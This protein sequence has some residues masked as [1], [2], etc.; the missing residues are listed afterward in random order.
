MNKLNFISIIVL[1][2]TFALLLLIDIALAV[3]ADL[4]INVTVVLG[5][6][7]ET[8]GP[9]QALF[10][11]P[12]YSC[13]TNRY[14]STTGSDSNNGTASDNA[15]AW[16]TIAHANTVTPSAG[17]CINVLAG[18]YSAGW[19]PTHGGSTAS[20]TGYVVYRCTTLDGCIVNDSGSQSLNTAVFFQANYVIVD[21]FEF[22]GGNGTGVNTSGVGTCHSTTLCGNGDAQALGQ[23]HIWVINNI[24]HG[25]GQS[26]AQ[27]NNGDYFYNVHNTYFNNSH[28]CQ[29]AQGSNISHYLPVAVSPYTPTA[30]DAN[31][32]VTGNTGTHFRQFIMWNVLY[33]AYIGCVGTS[34]TDGNGIIPDDWFGDQWGSC[35]SGTPNGGGCAYLNGGLIAFNVSYNNGGGAV[36]IFNTP[37]VTIANN[38]SFNSWLDTH[39][40]GTFRGTTDDNGSYGNNFINN[41]SYTGCGS[42]PLNSNSAMG[43]YGFGSTTPA[44]STTLNNGGTLSSG[45]TSLKVTSAATFPGGATWNATLVSNSD[46]SLPGGNLIQIG[47]EIMWVTAGWGTTTWT[48]VRGYNGTTAASHADGSTVLWLQEYYSNNITKTTSTCSEI[49][50]NDNHGNNSIVYS[51]TAN[52]E[53][54]SP[55]WVNVG[56]TSFGGETTQPNGANFALAGGSAAIGYGVRTSPFDFLPN[57]AN[58]AGACASQLTICP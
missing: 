53:A 21:G 37:Y 48:V 46:T 4:T 3:P 43:V 42:S 38:S 34:N 24:I 58:D 12:Y 45:A 19:Q 49:D 47:S 44:G 55:G 51:S 18:T 26:G 40:N 30:D 7:A 2:A 31:N 33:N 14:V 27:L 5:G 6:G 41:I 56:N 15:H 10:N 1:V 22:N 8:P 57:Q 17:W 11:T 32:R 50:L 29:A 13:T 28:D 16:L 35:T 23:H 54:T 52:K 20:S 25:Y 9:S 36:H 39:N